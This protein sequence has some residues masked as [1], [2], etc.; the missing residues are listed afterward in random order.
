[1]H[2]AATSTPISHRALIPRPT[3][4]HCVI[5]HP[6]RRPGAPGRCPLSHERTPGA[7]PGLPGRGLHR[8]I[9]RAQDELH[10]GPVDVDFS[11]GP[12]GVPGE[13]HVGGLVGLQ[14]LIGL[15]RPL[16]VHR[17]AVVPRLLERPLQAHDGPGIQ[18][19]PVR[20]RLTGHLPQVPVQLGLQQQE[21]V[22]LA[23][24]RGVGDVVG[25]AIRLRGGG[26]DA[27]GARALAARI[28][29]D[30]GARLERLQEPQREAA[31]RA[32]ESRRH[33]LAYRGARL[34][35]RLNRVGAAQQRA[36]LRPTG[37]ARVLAYLHRVVAD[38]RH[39]DLPVLRIGPRRRER[40]GEG[41]LRVLSRVDARD[42]VVGELHRGQHLVGQREARLAVGHH[43][44]GDGKRDHGHATRLGRHVARH[45]GTGAEHVGVE[46]GLG[47]GLGG[48]RRREQEGQQHGASRF[49]CHGG[50]SRGEGT[51]GWTRCAG[52]RHLQG[53]SPSGAG[54]YLV[55]EQSPISLIFL[56]KQLSLIPDYIKGE[57]GLPVRKGDALEDRWVTPDV[58]LCPGRRVGMLPFKA[59]STLLKSL[60]M[61]GRRVW[62]RRPSRQR[63]RAPTG[64]TSR[65]PSI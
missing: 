32:L 51:K 58:P 48:G 52:G 41:L 14:G 57:R 42:D 35:R 1:M 43:R 30:R 55:Y 37:L 20:G 16:E 34:P 26:P 15:G 63:S 53:T 25:E 31:A 12:D 22:P 56:G 38:D 9:L 10:E 28:L 13:E 61:L 45:D 36:P 7:S 18:L 44:G 24:H 64:A 62:S 4:F 27:H 2:P 11:T 39:A 8:A 19:H 5:R 29:A 40:G 6:P 54:V 17:A 21:R 47:L 50:T 33:G 23:G 3:A 59:S 60:W 65:W 46:R 49:G